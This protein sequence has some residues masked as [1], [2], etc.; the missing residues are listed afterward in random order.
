ML[1]IK[2]FNQKLDLSLNYFLN[3]QSAQN[4]KVQSG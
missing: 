3:D 1:Q 2:K 4:G